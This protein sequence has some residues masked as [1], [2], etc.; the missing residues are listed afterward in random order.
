MNEV[1][2]MQ[3]SVEATNGLER[4]MTVA[5]PAERVEKEVENRLKT[6]SRTAKLAGFRPG[7]VPMKVIASKYGHQVRQEVLD[8]VTQ[9][10]FQEAVMQEKLQPAG[11]PRIEPRLTETGKDFEYTAVF[12]V[13]PGIKLAPIDAIKIDKP[14]AEITETDVDNMLQKLRKQR[15]GWQVVERPAALEDQVMIDFKGTLDAKEFAGNEGKNVPLILGSRS[16]I[17]GFEEQLLGT[18]AGDELTID[19]TFPEDYHVK[20]LAGQSVSFAIKVHSVSAPV[21]PEIDEE[22]IRS[23][24]VKEGSLEAMRREVKDG[25]ILE[26][27]EVIKGKV[28]TQVMDQLYTS[29]PLELPK[30]LVEGEIINLMNQARTTLINQGGKPDD[31]P[32]E[33]DMFEARAR[34]RAALG[35]LLSEIINDNKFKAEASKIRQAIENIASTYDDPQEVIKWYYADRDRLSQIET[36]VLED[37]V[38]EW[39]LAHAAITETSTTFDEIMKDRQA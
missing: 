20:D 26:M 23:H 11:R 4:R 33:R 21:L 6:L 14:V 36:I 32:L 29:N 15:I 3:V 8:E 17:A 12:E 25:M 30:A 16:F 31:I 39:I 9:R 10:T 37:Q 1:S 2:K 38:V 18:R 5:I 22:F 27:E 13:Y 34:R 35:L 7:K 24:G 19:V 28:K